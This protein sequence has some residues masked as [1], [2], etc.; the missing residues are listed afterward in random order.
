M[1]FREVKWVL[2]PIH[3]CWGLWG[4]REQHLFLP[5]LWQGWKLHTV[6]VET[7]TLPCR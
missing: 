6:K 7:K 1:P 4:A 5:T 2:A 3:R